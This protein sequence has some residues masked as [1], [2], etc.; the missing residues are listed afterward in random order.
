VVALAVD[1]AKLVG[2][3]VVGALVVVVGAFVVVV[4]DAVV[5]ASLT[6]A[7]LSAGSARPKSYQ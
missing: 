6:Q 3:F 1:S 2:A 7:H 5:A 4:V